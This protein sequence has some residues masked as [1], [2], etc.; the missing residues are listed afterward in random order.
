MQS[1]LSS[2]YRRLA[3]WLVGVAVVGGLCLSLI[4]ALSRA[5]RENSLAKASTKDL[6]AAY[7]KSPDDPSTTYQL[8]YQLERDGH[9]EDARVLMEKLVR[10]QPENVTYWQGL[11]RCASESGHAIDALDAYRKSCELRP[12]WAEGHLKRGEIL[13]SA[14]LT[15][16]AL[17][18][19]DQG[20]KIDPNAETNVEPWARCLIAKGRD[21]EAW[22]RIRAAM[23]KIMVSD[24][25]YRLL[26]D[27]AIR[28]GRTAEFD[29]LIDDRISYTPAYPVG[30][31]RILQLQVALL[32]HPNAATLNDMEVI[33]L[34]A[35]HD[36]S[37]I[38]ESYAMLGKI[39]MLRGNLA[40]AES[41]F[42]TGRK[43]TTGDAAGCLKGLVE[44]YRQTG[45]TA[46]EKE[47]RDQ[48]R[49]MTGETPELDALRRQALSAPQNTKALLALAKGLSDAGKS[50][51]A[52]SAYEDALA[53]DPQD[54]AALAQRD[55]LRRKALEQLDATSRK[56]AADTTPQ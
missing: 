27:L 51:E 37:P 20:A 32:D 16:E 43:L 28:L 44:L 39:R 45:R 14:G 30:K 5:H 12:A 7:S 34:D 18:E 40:G 11:A 55:L 1:T 54:A 50:G 33:A 17:R 53:I 48:L 15:T 25:C 38:P 2:R 10:K 29:K 56:T 26:T 21:Q 46:Q 52:A 8:A 22:D 24:G 47:V 19:Y 4:V 49:K 36:T 41:A 9:S 31:Y 23:K 35:T 13:A 6:T 42:K 3:L